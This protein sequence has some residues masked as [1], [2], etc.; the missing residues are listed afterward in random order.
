M[1]EREVEIGERRE[2]INEK[3]GCV[4]EAEIRTAKGKNYNKRKRWKYVTMKI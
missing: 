3:C 2:D 1:C 4:G